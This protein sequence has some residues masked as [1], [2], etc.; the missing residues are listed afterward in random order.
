MFDLIL[1]LKIIVILVATTIGAYTDYKTSYIYNWITYPLILIGLVFLVLESF[2]LKNPLGYVYLIKVIAIAVLIYGIGYLFYYFGKMGG[3]D[4]KLFLG[5]HLVLPYY[6]GQVTILWLLILSS[7]LA[8]FF[9]SLKYSF[10]LIIILDFKHWRRLIFKKKHRIIWALIILFLFKLLIGYSMITLNLSMWFY[11]LL[12][13]VALG[14]KA[15]IFE[16]EIRK[17]IYLKRK[18]VSE[19][20]DGD[21]LAVDF[22]SKSLH[23]KLKVKDRQVLEERDI[24][25]IKK[26]NIKTIPIFD[27]LPRFGPYILLGL[28]ALL[29]IGKN[30]II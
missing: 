29:I 18:K 24:K 21:V 16:E 8:V 11:L 10:K 17:Y 13:P 26:M 9:V 22:I 4:I 23:E 5:M 25:R 2:I 30:L 7:L 1:I 15:A 6:A 12:I 14:L 3:G 27:N 19:L 20:E 28:I